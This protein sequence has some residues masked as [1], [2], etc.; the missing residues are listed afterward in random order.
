MIG[1]VS[2]EGVLFLLVGIV[3]WTVLIATALFLLWTLYLLN[4]YLRLRIAQLR[5]ERRAVHPDP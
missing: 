4:T 2:G 3:S 5:G 1:V